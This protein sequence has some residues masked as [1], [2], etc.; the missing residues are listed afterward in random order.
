[1]ALSLSTGK[2]KSQKFA[3]H[4]SLAVVGLGA[5]GFVL[6]V[7]NMLEYIKGTRLALIRYDPKVAAGLVIMS[8]MRLLLLY[9]KVEFETH[10]DSMF[11]SCSRENS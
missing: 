7:F 4:M 2:S 11:T 6:E 10:V 5:I 9:S 8:L 3:C 1:M